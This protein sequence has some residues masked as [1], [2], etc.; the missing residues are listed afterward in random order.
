MTTNSNANA[1]TANHETSMPAAYGAIER[2]LDDDGVAYFLRQNVSA[3]FVTWVNRFF[4]EPYIC[5]EDDVLDFGCGGGHL[6]NWLTCRTKTGVD[7]NPAARTSA[8]MLGIS[9]A[10]TLDEL[11][12][13]TFSRI[14]T[15]HAL[16]HVPSPYGALIQLKK[17]L[18]PDG[19]FIWLSP[20]DDWRAKHQRLWTPNDY[21]QHI[22]TWT[23]LLL[24][25]LL[26]TTGYNPTSVTVVT[27]AI[28][29]AVIAQRLWR[30]S[31]RL[32]HLAA[33]L[34]AAVQNRRQILAIATP[35]A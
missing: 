5:P 13:H 20:I 21:D 25:N 33:R 12:G 3:P 15:S 18:R 27:H 24:G 23:P 30:A 7:I 17:L 29:P 4:F 9:T 26:Q 1:P 11:E 19:L 14:I 32:F 31:P 35:A 6:L 22:Y 34:W 8:N 16:E 10:A 28:P 2:Y